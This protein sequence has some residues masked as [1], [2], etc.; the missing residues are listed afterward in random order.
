MT[1]TKLTLIADEFGDL[2]CVGGGFGR[3]GDHLSPGQ[4][5]HIHDHYDPESDTS[6]HGL[7]RVVEVGT[8]IHTAPAGGTSYVFVD[9]ETLD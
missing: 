7:A 6:Y 2:H 1:T 8:R 9:A 4:E 5:V 3:Y